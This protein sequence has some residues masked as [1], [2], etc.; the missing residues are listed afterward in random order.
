MMN[1]CNGLL[2]LPLLILSGCQGEGEFPVVGTLERD[3][4]VLTAELHEPIAAIHVREGERV[5]AGDRL[6]ELD[7]R[8]AQAELDQLAARRDQLRRRLDELLRGPRREII[9]EAQARLRATES[10]VVNTRHEYERNQRLHERGLSSERELDQAR[11]AFEVATGE[12][13]AA[14]A[15]L[16]ALLE[17]TT[18]E[19]LDQARAA[20]TEAEAAH[21]RQRL[22]LERLTLHSPRDA[23]VEALPFEL[24][25]SPPAGA[26]VAVLH[27]TDRPPY[28]R[29]Y[30][31]AALRARLQPGTRVQVGVDGRETL[32]GTVRFL[33]DEAAF[34]PYF[35]LTEHDADR[36]SY[37]AEIDIHD[38]ENLPT[39]VPARVVSLSDQ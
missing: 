20:L 23:V 24:G 12:R 1:K 8:R 25:E 11:A 2:L 13:D 22:T 35:A 6:L 19:E 10:S 39:G 18:I 7:T 14:R 28:A 33:A 5:A 16:E 26:A 3:R 27:A 37:L 29:V 4:I 30:V 34:T 32:T 21:R 17:G 31:P 38:G 15:N 9:D 36:L